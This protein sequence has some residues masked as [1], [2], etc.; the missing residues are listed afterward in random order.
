MGSGHPYHFS[1]FKSIK[2]FE[3]TKG[4]LIPTEKGVRLLVKIEA[5]FKKN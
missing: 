3:R 5:L 2:L 4:R 1:H